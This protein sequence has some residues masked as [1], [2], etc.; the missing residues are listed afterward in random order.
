MSP[1]VL[2]LCGTV[3]LVI[4]AH[5]SFSTLLA[6]ACFALFLQQCA[7]VGH[8]SA[9]NGITHGACPPLLGATPAALTASP[10][11]APSRRVIDHP[12]VEA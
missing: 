1:Q 8:D 6:A 4:Q 2:L 10:T 12:R 11:A 5:D 3:V 7:F 9:H